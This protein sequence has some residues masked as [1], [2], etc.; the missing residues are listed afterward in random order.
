M[1]TPYYM[2]I[3]KEIIKDSHIIEIMKK[4]CLQILSKKK[5]NEIENLKISNLRDYF[6]HGIQGQRPESVYGRASNDFFLRYGLTNLLKNYYLLSELYHLGLLNS[7]KNVLD[8]G[9]GPGTFSLAYL[10]LNMKHPELCS[11]VNIVMTDRVKEF[12]TLFE[13]LWNN[14]E[15]DE[16][17]FFNITS[18]QTRIDKILSPEL[19]N[20]DMIVFSN[21]L[22][23]I[24]RDPKV[25][26]Q[27]AEDLVETKATIFIIDYLDDSNRYK[28]LAELLNL[29]TNQLLNHYQVYSFYK[30]PHWNK[31]F[32]LVNLDPVPYPFG[33]KLNQNSKI[34]SN[35]KFIKAILVPRKTQVSLCLSTSSKLVMRYKDAWERHD[36]NILSD[37]FT[38][39][40]E[41]WEK[42]DQKPFIGIDG[43]CKYWRYNAQQQKEVKFTPL[44]ITEDNK[45][46]K[47]IWD[48]RFYRND[49]ERWMTLKGIFTAKVR[50]NKIYHF[51]EKFKK[52]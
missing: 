31:L 36:V 32:Q 24:L 51:E 18:V 11:Q 5:N 3:A 1:K 23:E 9:C 39:D 33:M 49:L 44:F 16:K 28:G 26:N 27:L 35:V 14:I 20:P 47:C 38:K 42:Q 8:L 6:C 34:V 46:F 50:N 10:L 40:V 13:T 48:C 17:K 15:A 19:N 2:N 25:L 7:V 22:L 4:L 30:W 45:E 37:L 21:S 52:V 29:F 12:L 41:Y 43:L